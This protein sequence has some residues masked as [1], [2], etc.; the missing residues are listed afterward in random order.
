MKMSIIWEL[1]YWHTNLIQH[2]LN[3]MH[4]EKNIFDNVLNTVMDIKGKVDID[5]VGPNACLKTLTI[6][7][8]GK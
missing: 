1:P 3:V 5:H 7:W 6:K 2:N 4:I 8:G